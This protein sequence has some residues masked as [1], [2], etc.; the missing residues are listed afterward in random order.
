MA[1]FAVRADQHTSAKIVA[2]LASPQ[3]KG[4]GRGK[5]VVIVMGVNE[6]GFHRADHDIAQGR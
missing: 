5:F 4:S 6:Q 1:G 3:F 2:H